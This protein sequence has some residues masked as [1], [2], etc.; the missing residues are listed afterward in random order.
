MILSQL[1][2]FAAE[3][4]T[5]MDMIIPIVSALGFLSIGGGLAVFVLPKLLNRYILDPIGKPG[6]SKRDWTSMAI[7]FA[8]LLALVPLTYYSKASPLMGAFI[9]GLVFCSDHGTHHMFV[10][11]FK[12]VMQW[13]LRIFFAASIG[14]QVPFAKFGNPT[15]LLQ[16]CFFTLALLGK[17][18][19][20]F[21]VPNFMATKRFKMTHLRDCLVVGFSMAAEGEFAFVIAVFAV[22]NGMIT[23]ELY[24][25]VVLAVLASTILAPLCLESS[26]SYFNKQAQTTVLGASPDDPAALLEKGIRE[27]TAVFFTIQTKSAPGWGLQTTIVEQLQKL[28]LDVIDHRSWHPRPTSDSVANL[29]NEVYVKDDNTSTADL[30]GNDAQQRISDREAEIQNSIHRAIGQID[31]VVMVQRWFPEIASDSFDDDKS[32]HEQI[33]DA[34]SK[35]LHTSMREQQQQSTPQQPQQQ[36]ARMDDDAPYGGASL[37]RRMKQIKHLDAMFKGRL[38]GLFRRDNV[39]SRVDTLA[40]DDGIELLDTRGVGT[41]RREQRERFDVHGYEY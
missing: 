28:N 6:D 1:Q 5:T 23:Q 11:Q 30:T 21:M 22:T 7:M 20:G 2:A 32:V 8:L 17:V 10:H 27:R 33:L 41:G 29:V 13:L 40:S 24:A 9:A 35:A 37:T 31:A 19:V 39:I 4:A 25:A 36:Y 12:R 38:E 15:V 3:D 16:G 18:A 34:T 14:F 26:I